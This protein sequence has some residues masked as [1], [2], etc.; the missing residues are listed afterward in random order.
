MPKG[1]II[2][3]SLADQSILDGLL[4]TNTELASIDNAAP[5]QPNVWTLVSFDIA[6]ADAAAFAEKLSRSLTQ[7]KW[8]VDIKSDEEVYVVFKDKVFHYQRSDDSGRAEAVAYARS[9]EIPESQ[10]DW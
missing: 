1:I 7:G 4:V 2:K 6:E 9:L 8:Y 3:E 5:G 10:L